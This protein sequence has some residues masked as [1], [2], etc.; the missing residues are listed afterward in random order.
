MKSPDKPTH[1]F[2]TAAP[3]S[4]P[5]KKH[6]HHRRPY[7]KYADVDL[8][9]YFRVVDAE[10]SFRA[11]ASKLQH[12]SKSRLAELYNE[13]KRAGKPAVFMKSESRGRKRA[14]TVEVKAAYADTRTP[15]N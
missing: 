12:L 3:R 2:R 6:R 13:W 11:A 8:V 10:H 15:F 1:S 5:K 7:N 14:F 4:S 9:P